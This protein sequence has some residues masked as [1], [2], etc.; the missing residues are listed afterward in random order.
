MIKNKRNFQIVIYPGI[1]FGIRTYES[2]KFRQTVFYLPF[3]CLNI[4]TTKTNYDE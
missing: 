1:L 4:E 3:I 2:E